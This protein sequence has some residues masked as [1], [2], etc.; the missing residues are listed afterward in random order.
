MNL[1]KLPKI[2]TRSQKRVGRGIG[3]GKGGHTSGRGQ[4]GQKARGS[5]PL[6]FTGTK[7]KKSLVKK[8]PLLRGKGK[9]K[10]GNGPVII[11]LGDLAL[12]PEKFLVSAENLLKRGLISE[13]GLA[14][15]VKILNSGEI[16]KAMTVKV[17]ISARAAEKITKAGGTVEGGP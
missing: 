15:G 5:V 10:P 9:L 7:T 17:A 16:E 14:R 3:S 4:K 6:L 11:K 12:L 8:I 13:E 2:V 1:N